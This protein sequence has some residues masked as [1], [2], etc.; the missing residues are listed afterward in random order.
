M[1]I[2]LILI[3]VACL[4]A[5]VT[6]PQAAATQGQAAGYWI[7]DSAN[8]SL[9]DPQSSGLTYRYGE[10]IHISDNSAAEHRR[11]KL[12]RINPKT[13]QL[14]ANPIPITVAE[15]LKAGCFGELLASYPD[16]EALTWDRQDDTV[17]IT[18]TED[19]SFVQLSEPCR[20][21]FGQTN[22]TDYPSLLVKIKTDKALTTA[23]VVAVR[24]VQFPS[25]AQVGNFAN[26]GIEGLAI[27]NRQQ[28][29]LALEKNQANAPMIFSIGY[30]KQFWQSDD[31]VR[32]SDTAFTL[33][34]PDNKNHPINALDYLPS[35][36]A[37][38]PGY[39][40]AAARNDDQLWVIDISQQQP[41]I[42]HQMTYYADTTGSLAANAEVT[43][44]ATLVETAVSSAGN[45]AGC[46]A[47]ENMI[48]TAIE[49]V[50]VAGDIVYLVND[51]WKK[52]YP[53]NINCPANADNFNKFAP[54]LFKL[55]ID[56]RWF[57]A[58]IALG[59]SA[60]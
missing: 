22:S 6:Y 31:F 36:V 25:S 30:D 29:Y 19:S 18:V 26:D 35:P 10:L 38:H 56:P 21:R 39:L 43:G 8:Q 20:Q 12:I 45:T 48:Q 52:H 24:P 32:V 27:D 60:R 17:F 37:G 54:L 41:P 58:P 9:D 3:S 28:L 4:G 16:Y 55:F 46:P 2:L 53:D 44:G 47:F 40:L 14:L 5:C 11:N 33:P 34:L 57:N 15:H 49:G 13:G 50:A 59:N 51:P 7:T 23:Q 1:R 42:V